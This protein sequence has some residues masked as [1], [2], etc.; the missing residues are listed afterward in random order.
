MC[1]RLSVFKSPLSH[2]LF[3]SDNLATNILKSISGDSNPI[4]ESE[5][6]TSL[7]SNFFEAMGKSND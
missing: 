3:S 7:I 5:L 2:I 1:G 6:L 4:S